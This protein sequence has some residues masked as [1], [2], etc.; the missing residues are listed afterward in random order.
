MVTREAWPARG[1]S[2]SSTQLACPGYGLSFE[3]RTPVQRDVKSSGSK[4]K[5][6]GGTDGLLGLG[7]K[8]GMGWELG[9]CQKAPSLPDLTPNWLLRGGAGGGDALS[10]W[11]EAPICSS[12]F[13]LNPEG[14]LWGHL[15]A[16]L[17][18]SPDLCR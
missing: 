3:P 12:L 13:C 2:F 14:G 18:T 8:L 11:L 17:G 10:V 6:A 15:C 5:K 16:G 1:V 9:M 4:Q 7:S